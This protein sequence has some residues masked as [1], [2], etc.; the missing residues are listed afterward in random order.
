MPIIYSLIAFERRV[1]AE[2][3]KRDEYSKAIL[4]NLPL[5]G[6]AYK[7]SYEHENKTSIY[8]V[9][10]GEDGLVLLCLADKEVELR[11]CYSF[12]QEIRTRFLGTYGESYK[13]SAAYS[14]NAFARVMNEQMNYYSHDPNSDQI[15]KA[16]Q[17]ITDVESKM[18]ENI[19]KAIDRGEK[20][21]SIMEKTDILTQE[22]DDF[23]VVAKKVERR[24]W[25]KDKKIIVAAVCCVLILL[26][27]LGVVIYFVIRNLIS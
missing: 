3:G 5:N 18:K 14:L 6:E 13:Q 8:H 1:L 12:L 26:A 23:K 24:M 11:I 27:I 20:I 4:N 17:K 15:K 10:V 7:K 21:D 22:A 19:G 16:R 9:M 25:W 2:Q